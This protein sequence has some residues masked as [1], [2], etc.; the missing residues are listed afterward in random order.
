MK[1]L[2]IYIVPILAIF[3][4]ISEAKADWS[5]PSVAYKCAPKEKIFS[6]RG[7]VE[8]NDEFYIPNQPG[9]TL[10]PDDG[11]STLKCHIGNVYIQA[12]IKA[13]PP[14][15]SGMCAEQAFYDIEKV[16]VNGEVV[17]G[18]K[19][20]NLICSSNPSLYKVDLSVTDDGVSI[21]TCAGDWDWGREYGDEMCES[22]EIKIK[23][24]KY[25]R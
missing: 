8:A 9:Y 21:Q 25:S 14:L 16:E 4:F 6:I 2:I 1:L 24:T 22:K 13:I 11:L 3:G 20:F 23:K 12:R 19:P 5:R 18:P 10:I 7:V 15:E 17:M